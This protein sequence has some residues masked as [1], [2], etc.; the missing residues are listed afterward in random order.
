MFT[1][2]SDNDLKTLLAYPGIA[3]IPA[4]AISITEISFIAERPVISVLL[5]ASPTISVPG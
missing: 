5:G 1:F 2:L 3:T 4:P